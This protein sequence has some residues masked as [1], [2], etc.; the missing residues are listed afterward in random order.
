M[1]T[2]SVMAAERAR[3][4]GRLDHAKDLGLRG[5]HLIDYIYLVER[6]RRWYTSA[7]S[8]GMITPFLAPGFV[9]ATFALTAEQKR[10]WLL[11]RSLVGRLVPEWAEVPFVSISTGKSTATR[12]CAGDGVEV[13][14]GLLDTAHGPIT[15]LICR[16][17][18]EKALTTAV[19]NDPADQ[20]TLQQ[21]TWLAVASEQLE[22]ATVRPA[23]AATFTR[24]SALP[25][26]VPR[27][28]ERFQRLRWLKRTRAGRALRDR[29]R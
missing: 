4:A 23:T 19:W 15:E 13:I 7:Y 26:P 16:D 8:I 17:T 14:A 29:L 22:P 3:I 20:R 1:A 10:D 24:M 25:R 27:R 18:V 5:L 6:V 28:P 11:H 21:F 2:E 9:A 12:I